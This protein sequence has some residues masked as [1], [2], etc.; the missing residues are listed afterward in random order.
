MKHICLFGGPG[1]GKS[2]ISSGLFNLMKRKGYSV[3]YVTEYAKGLTYSKS[4]FRLSDQLYILAKQHHPW[5]V[6]KSQIDYTV[7]DSPF[8]LGLAYTQE[9]EHLPLNEFKNLIISM[10]KT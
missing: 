8:I 7:N 9:T 3:E 2:T 4:T 6:L 10:Y 1:V 5:F